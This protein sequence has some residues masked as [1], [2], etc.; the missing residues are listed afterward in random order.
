[1]DGWMDGSGGALFFS[2]E[3]SRAEHYHISA[4]GIDSFRRAKKKDICIFNMA[5]RADTPLCEVLLGLA[6]IA[7]GR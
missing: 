4:S 2:W 7:C 5:E 3:Q 6:G 1:M